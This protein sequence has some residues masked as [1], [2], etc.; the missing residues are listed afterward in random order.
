MGVVGYVR[1]TAG[2]NFGKRE[3]D[4]EAWVFK[5]P[6]LSGSIYEKK[7]RRNNRILQRRGTWV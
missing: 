7:R 1:K 5:P 2:R 4:G 3:A 6:T